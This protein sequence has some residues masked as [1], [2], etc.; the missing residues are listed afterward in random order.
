M[1][2]IDHRAALTAAMT[3]R[4]RPL[5]SDWPEDLFNAMIERLTDITIRYEGRNAVMYDRR[6]T[7]LLVSELKAVLERSESARDSDDG[8]GSGG[9]AVSLLLPIL[10]DFV[11]KLPARI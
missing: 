3:A 1:D 9:P 11:V 7:D 2:D 6:S 5:C 8:A 4:L 10:A